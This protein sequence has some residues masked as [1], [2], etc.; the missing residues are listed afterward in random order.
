[1]IGTKGWS[2]LTSAG[3]SKLRAVISTDM[4]TTLHPTLLHIRKDTCNTL[5]KFAIF[6]TEVT[7]ATQTTTIFYQLTIQNRFM[8]IF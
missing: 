8:Y 4:A 3:E 7:H 2:I 5:L 1:M 6:T